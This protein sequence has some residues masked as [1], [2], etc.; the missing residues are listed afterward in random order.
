MRVEPE[1]AAVGKFFGRDPMY[2]IPK[3]QRSYAWENHEVQDFIKDLTN[4][5]EK[6]RL[7]PGNEINHFF[8]GIVSVERKVTGVVHQHEYELVDGQ[9]R[10]ATFILF[11]ASVISVYEEMLEEA[12]NNG[13]TT[14][15]KI[16]ENRISKLSE[17]FIQFDQEVN[18]N[19][20]TI[21]VLEL[22]KSDKAFFSNL[23]K[24]NNP[25]PSRDSH[26]RLISAFDQILAK[27]KSLYA[28]HSITDRLDNLEEFQK[29]IDNDFT[30]IHIITYDE[31]EAYKLFQVL[32]DRGKSLTEG[33]LLRAK[34]LELLEGFSTQQNLV[35]NLWDDILIDTSK[36]TDDHLRWIY[37]SHYGTRAGS[38][39]LFDDYMSRFFPQHNQ[40]I[41]VTDAQ[42]ILSTIQQLKEEFEISRKISNGIWPYSSSSRSIV[43]WDKNRLDLLIRELGFKVTLPILLSSYHLGE[44]KFS[45]IVQILEKFLFRYK[46]VC[47]QHIE[48]VVT[49]FHLHSVRMRLNPATYNIDDLKNELRII[50]NAR[51]NDT[52]FKSSLDTLAYK[53]GGGNKPTKYFLMALEH[54][55][56]WYDNGTVGAPKCLDKTRIYDFSSTTIEHV[57]PR[58]AHGVVQ[59]ANIEPFKNHLENLTFMGPTDNVLGGNDDFL[60]KKPIFLASSVSLNNDIGTLP[61]WTTTELSTRKEVL[62]N[63]ACAIFVV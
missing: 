49:I 15:E 25:T 56:R 58:N 4:C 20:F 32:N 41:V 6:R 23:I 38:T 43:Q 27:I 21:D 22:S 10:F 51:A 59:N 28:A 36:I 37:A 26:H 18:R 55:K 33:D 14:N 34:T 39:T 24:R 17:R 40:T 46:T 45:E 52:V 16:I 50:L 54:Y 12:K 9:Q 44:S 62:K 11:I 60:T 53:E 48:A 57:Y 8:G 47:N 42:A 35:E 3:Y 19:T 29:I 63:M 7:G 31:R 2:R 1:Y 5:Y 13:D 61:Q 30:L